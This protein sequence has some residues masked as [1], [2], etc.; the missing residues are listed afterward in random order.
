MKNTLLYFVSL[1]YIISPLASLEGEARIFWASLLI[2]ITSCYL[3]QSEITR[4]T[5][6]SKK[7][8]IHALCF[9]G[10]LI[11][12]GVNIM[13]AWIDNMIFLFCYTNAVGW[14]IGL[15]LANIAPAAKVTKYIA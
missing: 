9:L 13:A 4:Q 12:Q 3:A 14:L 2:V 7:V 15:F 5:P 8:I 1:L 10:C 11:P 6:I